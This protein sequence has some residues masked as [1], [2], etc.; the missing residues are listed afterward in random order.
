MVG[1]QASKQQQI[2]DAMRDRIRG[3][4]LQPGDELPQQRDIAEQ[5][6]CSSMPVSIAYRRL[7]EAGHV[8]RDGHRFR[9]A[10]VRDTPFLQDATV[11]G[12][13]LELEDIRATT[14]SETVSRLDVLLPSAD[15]IPERIIQLLDLGDPARA[16][17][18]REVYLAT[19][20]VSQIAELWV[21]RTLA[22]KAGTLL[23]PEVL[24]GGALQELAD[25]GH[26][27]TRLTDEITS[28]LATPGETELLQL[29]APQTPVLETNRIGFSDHD[30]VLVHRTVSVG[31]TRTYRMP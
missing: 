15:V 28:R 5:F 27:V 25:I 16:V 29:P 17:L 9:V 6:E 12:A 2:F 7:V 11:T 24:P 10:A 26:T 23:E 13:N 1:K 19:G 18:R 4:E 20:P 30:P 14:G 8:I 22:V 31:I 21:A 3:G